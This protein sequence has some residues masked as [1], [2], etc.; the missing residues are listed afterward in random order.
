M[1]ILFKVTWNQKY[2]LYNRYCLFLY[3]CSSLLVVAITEETHSQRSKKCSKWTT[4]ALLEGKPFS[5]LY[6]FY[7]NTS[8]FPRGRKS[9]FE[10][11]FFFLQLL[12]FLEVLI[13]NTLVKSD[14][15]LLCYKIFNTLIIGSLLVLLHICIF[16]WLW[17]GQTSSSYWYLQNSPPGPKQYSS[18]VAGSYREPLTWVAW[19]QFMGLFQCRIWKR[20]LPPHAYKTCD[21]NTL[22][23]LTTLVHSL[24]N[25]LT[26]VCWSFAQ[27]LY[28]KLAPKK[29]SSQTLSWGKLVLFH[30]NPSESHLSIPNASDATWSVKH[31]PWSPIS[32]TDHITLCWNLELFTVI[33]TW[34]NSKTSIFLYSMSMNRDE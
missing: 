7:P 11:F 27:S 14:S 4:D 34:K 12:Y 20:L 18:W 28:T 25:L 33:L 13:S 29:P 26:E 30:R 1:K 10:A 16:C 21:V 8:R 15:V 24:A 31:H 5:F 17:I 6:S 2:W 32:H 19:E 23:R 3:L 22:K 9:S